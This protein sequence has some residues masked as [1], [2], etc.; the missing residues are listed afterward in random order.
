MLH[1]RETGGRTAFPDYDTIAA[2]TNVASTST[3]GFPGHCDSA[4]D[5]LVDL[6]RESPAEKR[7][8]YWQ[9]LQPSR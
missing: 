1:A 5:A 3:D 9:R 4:V 8:L 6:V 7:P 2:K